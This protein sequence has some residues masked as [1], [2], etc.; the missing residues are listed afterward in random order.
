MSRKIHEEEEERKEEEEEAGFQNEDIVQGWIELPV[1]HFTNGRH[2]S[3]APLVRGYCSRGLD[4]DWS[5]AIDV[6]T[7]AR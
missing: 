2:S 6:T 1:V 4:W 7:V 5:I 3:C